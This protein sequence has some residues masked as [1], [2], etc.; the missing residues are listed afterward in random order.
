MRWFH[1]G[2][3]QSL[4]GSGGSKGAA[5]AMGSNALSPTAT[6]ALC[7]LTSAMTLFGAAVL[8]QQRLKPR[9]IKKCLKGA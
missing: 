8:Y 5:D 9:L 3:Y 1:Q 4:T 2:S 6:L 7:G